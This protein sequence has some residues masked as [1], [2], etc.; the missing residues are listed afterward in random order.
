[1]STT[2]QTS[3]LDLSARD[4]EGTVTLELGLDEG[5][6]LR[7][8]LLKATAEGATSLDDQLVSAALSKLGRA[9]DTVQATINLRRELGQ[10]GLDVA[11]MSDEQVRELGRR[12]S[13]AA[14]PA[15]RC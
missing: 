15:I 4:P 11:H 14:L 8:W 6:A 3:D 10:A 7:T 12:I 1:V 13:D 9:L 5:E 2:D